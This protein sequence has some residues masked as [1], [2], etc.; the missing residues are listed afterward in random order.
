[1][2]QRQVPAPEVCVDINE[3]EDHPCYNGR[4]VNH[5][6]GF[7]CECDAGW[8]GELCDIRTDAVVAYI[9]RGAILAIGVSCLVLLIILLVIIVYRKRQQPEQYVVGIDPDDDVRENII[10]YD[11]EGVGKCRYAG[12]LVFLS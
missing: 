9:G 11:E 3:C 8:A 2:G 10:H 4:C 5:A 1:M 6:Y 7:V 12:L